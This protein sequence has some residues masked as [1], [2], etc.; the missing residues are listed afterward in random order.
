[1][2]HETQGY[3]LMNFREKVRPRLALS[4][5]LVI[6]ILGLCLRLYRLD[7]QSVWGDEWPNVAHLQAPDALTYARLI[8]LEYPEQAHAPLFYFVNYYWAKWVGTDVYRLRLLPVFLGLLAIPLIYMLGK[9]VHSPFAGLVAAL[10]FALSPQHIWY[11][12]EIRPYSLLTPIAVLSTYALLRATREEKRRWWILNLALNAIGP[13]V[14]LF[15]VLLPFLQGLWLLILVRRQW[16][17]L[18]LWTAFQ[19]LLLLPWALWMTQL[20]FN[21]EHPDNMVSPALIASDVFA[22][23]IVTFHLDML[24]SWKTHGPEE[25]AP[26][27]AH[28]LKYHHSM[29]YALLAVFG[30]G[31]LRLV[32]PLLGFARRS[33]SRAKTPEGRTQLTDALLLLALLCVPGLVLGTLS[34][35]FQRPFLSPMYSM[36]NSAAL[37]IGIGMVL[38]GIR[39]APGKAVAVAIVGTLY[40]YQLG[41]TLPDTTRSDWKGAATQIAEQGARGDLVIEFEI[42]WP[43]ECMRVYLDEDKF[44]FR[45]VP[46]LQAALDDAATFLENNP[47]QH[48]W[49]VFES[50]FLV[51]WFPDYN[52]PQNVQ[53]DCEARNLVASTRALIGHRNLMM[54][55][56]ERAPQGAV[57]GIGAPMKPFAPIDFS[58]ILASCGRA[59]PSTHDVERLRRAIMFWPPLNKSFFLT[60]VFDLVEQGDFEL[61]ELL[62]RKLVSANP[63][64]GLGYLALGAALVGQDRRDEAR[65]AFERAYTLHAGLRAITGRLTDALVEP[66]GE[67]RVKEPLDTLRRLHFPYLSALERVASIAKPPR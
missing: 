11:S 50:A 32:Y 10:C 53:R 60:N 3:C 4:V 17:R 14:H 42:A 7:A 63:K 18:I 45:R 35:I 23:D 38:A 43:S 49:V 26:W 57:T 2:A 65:A 41:I 8:Q 67:G 48:V 24:P 28:R 59:N 9:L 44:P 27:L 54:V 1:M 21:N 51:W 64:F 29:D 19:L 47:S 20:P 30:L 62:A 5:L 46:T 55:R 16:R 66:G 61:A 12:Q 52:I 33:A 15:M 22:D 34:I 13:W 40:G 37:Y 6:V 56:V 39:F 36:Y 58:G 31:V 25:L